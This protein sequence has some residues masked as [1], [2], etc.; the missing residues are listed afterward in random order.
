MIAYQKPDCSVAVV[1]DCT[2][3]AILVV[4][5]MVCL[6]FH[7]LITQAGAAILCCVRGRFLLRLAVSMM[8]VMHLKK[9]RQLTA[10]VTCEEVLSTQAAP[11]SQ[12]Q[13]K[14][15]KPQH[16]VTISIQ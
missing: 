4:V 14:G 13:A 3:G 8:Y 1:G 10:I 5:L 12:A 7:L 2:V 16:S 11:A 9:R 6:V 15:F